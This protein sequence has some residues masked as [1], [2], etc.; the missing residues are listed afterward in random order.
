MK[1]GDMAV[2]KSAAWIRV[3]DPRGVED[4]PP[5]SLLFN[6][7]EVEALMQG[8]ARAGRALS[9]S[10]ALLALGMRFSRP[11]MR[12]LCKVL[13]AVDQRA[14][15]RGEP[16]LAVLVVRESDKL[17]GQGWWA[18]R[19]ASG[20]KYAGPWEGAEAAAHVAKI[21]RKAFRFWKTSA[22]V[23]AIDLS[24]TL[25]PALSLKGR[26]GRGAKKPGF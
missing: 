5:Q 12:A 18:W 15:V 4:A 26:G 21:Q 25:T 11:K 20:D 24:E 6:V 3:H 7:D 9:Y 10:E 14:A 22:L 13:D 16:E 19:Q 8:S 2:R 23:P 17:P 1:G